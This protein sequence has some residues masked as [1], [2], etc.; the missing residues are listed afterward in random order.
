MASFQYLRNQF[1]FSEAYLFSLL[2]TEGTDV[3]LDGLRQSLVDWLDVADFTTLDTALVSFIEPV[4]QTLQFAYQPPPQ[5]E[6]KT[7]SGNSQSSA[8][9]LYTDFT[10]QNPVGVCFAVAPLHPP[11]DG[12][13]EGGLSCTL[14]GSNFA[15]KFIRLLRENDLK[16]GI[17]TNGKLWRLYHENEPMPY[18]TYFEVDLPALLQEPESKEFSLFARFFGVR[19]FYSSDEREGEQRFDEMKRASEQA[20][21]EIG[22]HLREK[23]ETILENICAG[24]V[25]D[26]GKERFTEAQREEIHHNAIYLLYRIMFLLYAEARNLL[27]MENP[28]YREKSL[29]RLI[30]IADPNSRRVRLQTEGIENPDGYELWKSL[31]QLC[32]EID[33][34]NAELE[35]APYDGGLFD[36][37][38][39]PYLSEHQMTNAYLSPVLYALAYY[40]KKNSGRVRL[41]PNQ[42]TRIN[43]R[44][45][46]VRHLGTLY[47]GILE[48]KLFVAEEPMVARPTKSGFQFLPEREAGTLKKTD[49]RLPIGGVYFAQNPGERKATGSYYTPEYIVEYIVQN[50]VGEKL[51][52]LKATLKQSL[53]KDQDALKVAISDDERIRFQRFIDRQIYDFV[54]ERVLSFRVLDPAMGSGHFLVNATNAIAN[55]ITELMNDTDWENPELDTSTAEWRRRVV[56]SCIFGVDLNPLAVELSKLSLWIT[57]AAKDR[58]LSFL[59]HHLKC[60]NSLIG[61]K[62]SELGKYPQTKTTQTPEVQMSLFTENRDFQRDIAEAIRGYLDIERVVTRQREDVETKKEKLETIERIL[63]P[64]R[65]LCELYTGVYFENEFSEDDY[66]R[67]VTEFQPDA[68]DA[69]R[70]KY[71]VAK[72]L[73]RTS[74]RRFFHW[75]LE[76]PEV[77]F[78]ENGGKE[79]PGFD[80]VIGNPPYVDVAENNFT[81][82]NYRTTKCRNL[83]SYMFETSVKNTCI[84][85]RYGLI[86]PL[87]IICSKR[88]K[89]LQDFIIEQSGEIYISNYSERPAKIFSDAEQKIAIAYGTKNLKSNC[90]VFAT[91]HYRWYTGE[92]LQIINNIEYVACSKFRMEYSI[93]KLGS[94]TGKM[95]LNKIFN[96]KKTIGDYLVPDSEYVLHYHNI[97]RYWLKAYD[98]IPLYKKGNVISRSS[99]CKDLRVSSETHKNLIIAILNSSLF[100]WFWLLYSDCFHLTQENIE[101]FPIT[102]E[103]LPNELLE[104][105]I[106]KTKMLMDDYQK[107]SVLKTVNYPTGEITIQEFY[108][109]YSK[110]IIDDIDRLLG[111]YY[112]FSEDEIDFIINYDIQFRTD[113]GEGED[114]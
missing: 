49:R 69:F 95:I 71:N 80:A 74:G 23:I 50:T 78:E 24:F 53:A 39:H 104:S 54:N 13:K 114:E 22:K 4:L 79:N 98:F 103:E 62:L 87:S 101:V 46:S 21:E 112:G 108:P 52:E 92:I 63:R 7:Q 20:T 86:V 96:Q 43:Y 64:Y 5:S 57:A 11:V 88:M 76:F 32:T 36:A 107:N 8:R 93:P 15:E 99:T 41:L 89:S 109:R 113:I 30:E 59:D 75:E 9:L 48:Y 83:Y 14:K 81:R 58:P 100:Y 90:E 17:L 106:D 73:A 110:H 35:V 28:K 67:L 1:L 60:G 97:G 82:Y 33:L 19:A 3:S 16:W 94:E 18:E 42:P 12:G 55:F 70:E 77:F 84:G 85:G 10:F 37:G 47:E 68:W 51:K 25:A 61:A 91:M 102:L 66:S 65:E 26:E 29:E 34:G 2:E 72:V 56:E 105:L 27:P 31:R 6:P 45:M 44:D 38:A 111:C 40:E